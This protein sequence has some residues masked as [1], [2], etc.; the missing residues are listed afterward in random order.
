MNQ[1]SKLIDIMGL[2]TLQSASMLPNS[3]TIGILNDRQQTVAF[4]SHKFPLIRHE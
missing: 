1:P 4:S 3:S 2:N